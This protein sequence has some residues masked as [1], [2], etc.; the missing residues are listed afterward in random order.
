MKINYK[1]S[2]FIFTSSVHENLEKEDKEG[3]GDYSK[4]PIFYCC[5]EACCVKFDDQICDWNCLE[6]E[7]NIID[8]IRE[9][10]VGGIVSIQGIAPSIYVEDLYPCICI[11]NFDVSERIKDINLT[12]CYVGDGNVGFNH[13]IPITTHE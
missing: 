6:A 7:S 5:F 3:F 8:E 13:G 10:L 9:M 12:H 11:D 4:P 2:D 1:D